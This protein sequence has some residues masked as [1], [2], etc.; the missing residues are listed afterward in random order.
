LR[1]FVAEFEAFNVPERIEE[2][3]LHK[4]GRIGRSRAQ[5]G[6]RPLAQRRS[7]GA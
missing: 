3:L 2:G 6:R 1:P 4:V 5:R 7:G